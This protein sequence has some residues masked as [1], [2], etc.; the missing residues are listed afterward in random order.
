MEGQENI[1]F[2]ESSRKEIFTATKDSEGTFKATKQVLP[3]SLNKI[4]S[5]DGA[6]WNISYSESKIQ[7]LFEDIYTEFIFGFKNSEF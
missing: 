4:S 1:A 7:I 5:E 6:V 3:D 2:F